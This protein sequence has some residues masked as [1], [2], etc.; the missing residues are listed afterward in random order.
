MK[1]CLKHVVILFAAFMA[2]L[3]FIVC[4]SMNA[5]AAMPVDKTLPAI[6]APKASE[7]TYSDEIVIK[8]GDSKNSQVDSYIIMRKKY[9]DDTWHKLAEVSNN[10]NKYIDKI[11][12]N[13]DYYS[14]KI[15]T[16]K[17]ING[18]K[19]KSVSSYSA[20][21]NGWVKES[22]DSSIKPTDT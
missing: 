7:G 3:C 17:V 19:Y 2:A 6:T 16:T 4:N 11:T 22:A 18:V 14:Y 12:G 13:I 1:R 8:W 9:G 21:V 10:T 15:L 20:V 5:K